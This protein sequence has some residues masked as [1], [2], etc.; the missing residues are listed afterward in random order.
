MTEENRPPHR[1]VGRPKRRNTTNGTVAQATGSVKRYYDRVNSPAP[2]GQ[3]LNRFALDGQRLPD[4]PDLTG[5]RARLRAAQQYAEQELLRTR[6]VR[7]VLT[8][9][10]SQLESTPVPLMRTFH[11]LSWDPPTFFAVLDYLIASSGGGYDLVR[12]DGDWYIVM[13]PPRA[14]SSAARGAE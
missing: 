3:S 10:C 8:L 12:H 4:A 13:V 11:A 1:P 2:A 6:A 5:A 7:L 14:D 9:R